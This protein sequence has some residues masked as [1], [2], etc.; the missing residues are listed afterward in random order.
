MQN[1]LLLPAI[2]VITSA[3]VFYTIGVW[4][5]KLQR[6]LRLWHVIL[7]CMGISADIGGT[8]LMEHIARQTGAHDNLHA[9]TG[10]IAVVLMLIHAIWAVY[11]YYK[12]SLQAKRN[13]SKFSI[14]VWAIWLIPYG[15][16]V[17]IGMTTHP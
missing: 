6:G 14:L 9:I 7:F 15:I 1:H 3:L 12:G 16:G 5:E 2:I 11:T 8:T 13:F 10:G 17:Y 4:G